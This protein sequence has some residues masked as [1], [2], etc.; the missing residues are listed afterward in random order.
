MNKEI[1]MLFIILLLALVLCSFLGGS[2]CSGK[3]GF[4][5]QNINGTYKGPNGVKAVVTDT[6]IVFSNNGNITT[7][8]KSSTSNNYTSSN[9]YKASFDSNGKLIITDSQG[10]NY[11]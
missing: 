8:T 6:S 2:N 1:L 3:E 7:L 11:K 4:T 10:N 9:G 5:S